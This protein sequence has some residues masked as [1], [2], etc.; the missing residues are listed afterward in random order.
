MLKN[1]TILVTGGAGF[2][3]SHVVDELVNNYEVVIADNNIKSNFKYKN[4]K[5]IY[6]NCNILSNDL[7]ELFE[8][9]KFDA[10]IH[11][12]AQVS[13]SYSIKNPISDAEVNI[14]GTIKLLELCKRFRVNKFFAA[15]SAAVYGNPE[16]LPINENHPCSPISPYGISKLTMEKYII[17][18][19]LNYMILRFAN[20]YGE[21][22]SVEGEAGVVAIFNNAIK[23][24]ENLYIDG[25]GEQTRDF[26]Y[27]KDV[28]KV[29]SIAL[30]KF[31]GNKIVNVST[32]KPCTINSLV[33]TMLR[34]SNS[35]AK[36]FYRASR[37]GDIRH[38]RLDNSNLLNFLEVFT[39]TNL[40]DGLKYLI[41]DEEKNYD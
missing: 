35:K 37:S 20:V 26:I 31:N 36:H 33:E 39:Y 7:E 34:I 38:S 22:Q 24:K 6:Y 2:I 16:S 3:G 17:N 8:K 32:N 19:G 9:Y 40:E 15:S 11:L 18:S 4:S 41:L 13:V 5:A 10:V 30:A 29:F 12:A 1:K 23:N 27:V 25:D 14:I 28:A 21:R